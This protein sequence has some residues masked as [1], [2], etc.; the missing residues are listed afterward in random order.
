MSVDKEGLWYRVLKARWGGG[1]LT[2]GCRHCSYWW[3]TVCNVRGGVGVGVRCWFDANIRRVVGDGRHTL[4]WH[5][6][7]VGEI[8]SRNKFPRLFDLPV[9]QESSVDELSRLGWMTGGGGGCGHRLLAWEEESVRECF[10]LLHNDV[11]Q[12]H[13]HDTWKWLLDPIHGYSVRGVYRFFTATDVPVVR[14]LTTDV[15]NN[16]DPSK[17]SLFAWR[18]LRN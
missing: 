7:W 6:N 4:F 17:V 2:R 12:D 15:W 18:L 1:A 9:N 8:P 5:D 16:I 11:L 3:R 10:V 14:N 13:T